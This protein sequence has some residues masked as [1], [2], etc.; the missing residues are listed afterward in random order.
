MRNPLALSQNSIKPNK[1][2]KLFFAEY[3]SS[4]NITKGKRKE[5]NKNIP[6]PTKT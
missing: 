4:I 6:F 3:H 5:Q 1:I 2:Q